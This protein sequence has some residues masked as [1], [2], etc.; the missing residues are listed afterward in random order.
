M[1]KS[2]VDRAP[3]FYILRFCLCLKRHCLCLKR[4]LLCLERHCLRFFGVLLGGVGGRVWPYFIIHYAESALECSQVRAG[5]DLRL[6]D[7]RFQEASLQHKPGSC[8]HFT[9]ASA[10]VIAP[11]NRSPPLGITPTHL[12]HVAGRDFS[13]SECSLPSGNNTQRAS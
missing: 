9:N 1:A 13:A 7:R 5:P 4:H 6:Q 10:T 8:R 12:D 2:F 11:T 3:F